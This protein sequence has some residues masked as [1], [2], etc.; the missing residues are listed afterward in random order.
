MDIYS[1]KD[2]KGGWILGDFEPSL[3]RTKDFEVAYHQYASGQFWDT[4][5]HRYTTEYNILIEGSMRVCDKD[6]YT[7]DVFVIHPGEIA[8]PVYQTDCKVIII[9]IPSIPGDKI[10]L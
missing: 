1:I 7:G 4:H 9:K 2:F 5:T 8:A 10:I 6:L 3:L